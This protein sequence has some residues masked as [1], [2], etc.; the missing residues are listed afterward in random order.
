MLH[1]TVYYININEAVANSTGIYVR[2][3]ICCQ[4]LLVLSMER[5]WVQYFSRSCHKQK[6][7]MHVRVKKLNDF[8]HN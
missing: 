6:K 7:K 1:Y 2:V 4:E 5:I 8:P 3:H